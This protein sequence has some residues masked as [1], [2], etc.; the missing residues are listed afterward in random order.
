[1]SSFSMFSYSLLLFRSKLRLNELLGSIV[2]CLT[3]DMFSITCCYVFR[4]EQFLL[5]SLVGIVFLLELLAVRI[6]ETS[7][8]C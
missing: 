8:V 7:D 2:I 4:K 5:C 3:N 1:M 6:V